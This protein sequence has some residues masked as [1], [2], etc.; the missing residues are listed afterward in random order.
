MTATKHEFCR[1]QVDD[2]GSSLYTSFRYVTGNLDR[3]N[4]KSLRLQ[5]ADYIR[6]R[7]KL[8][9]L[10]LES[11]TKYKTVKD[12]CN[13]IEKGN[14]SGGEF[15]LHALAMLGKLVIRVVSITLDIKVLNYG[16]HAES[17]KECVYILYDEEKNHYAPLY[18]INK[19]NLD[20]KSTIFQREDQMIRNLLDVFIQKDIYGKKKNIY[21]Y[22]QQRYYFLRYFQGCYNMV[23][24]KELPTGIDREQMMVFSFCYHIFSFSFK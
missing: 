1:E 8:H 10:I 22:K 14:L 12:Y 18:I 11:N 19:E 4:N 20:E 16:E 13:Q 21:T 5:V 6:G 23:Y 24:E 9:S 17:Y 7:E 2:D 15:E 3:V